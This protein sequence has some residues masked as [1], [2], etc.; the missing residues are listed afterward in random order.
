MRRTPD[1]TLFAWSYNRLPDPSSDLHDPEAV[2]TD[3]DQRAII[4]RDFGPM[5]FLAPSLDG[6]P[7]PY[8]VRALTRNTDSGRARA[9]ADKGVELVQLDESDLVASFSGAFQDADAIVNLL[10]GTQHSPR[11]AVGEAAIQCGVKVYFPSEF[12]M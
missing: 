11:D 5:S 12:G 10:G 4:L 1:Q 2:D 6:S 8:A 9:L 3:T 7:S